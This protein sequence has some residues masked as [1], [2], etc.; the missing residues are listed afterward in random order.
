MPEIQLA[1]PPSGTEGTYLGFDFGDRNIGVAVGQRITAT[2]TRLETIRATSNAAKWDAINR[3]V[4]E[5]KPA[6]FVVGLAYQLDGSENPITQPTLRFC[7]QLE[8][9]YH[10]PVHTMDETLSTMESK[11]IF[12]QSRTRCSDRFIDFKDEFAAQLILQ[13]WL[14]QSLPG[15]VSHV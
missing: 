7:R 8:G 10:L 12:Y 5:W 1:A 13:S 2:A 11:Q 6:A 14:L 9:R 3:L 4:N 15:G